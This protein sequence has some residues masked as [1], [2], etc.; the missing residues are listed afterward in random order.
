MQVFYYF[1]V[2]EAILKFFSMPNFV[3][4]RG[5]YRAFDDPT[6]Y[7]GSPAFRRLDDA[8]D[9]LASRAEN[10]IY[11]LCCD[12]VKIFNWKQHSIGLVGLRC[13]DVGAVE[14]AKKQ[15]HEPIMLI[16]GPKMPADTDLFFDLIALDLEKLWKDGL[17]VRIS[18]NKALPN[19]E[20]AP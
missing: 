14:A 2:K 3:A 15:F 7:Y 16:P 6:S 11:G 13:E 1:G 4:H 10:S 17:R 18:Q 19:C 8:V 5:K 20:S 9:S 12:W